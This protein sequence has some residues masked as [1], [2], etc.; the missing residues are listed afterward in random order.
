MGD[1]WFPLHLGGDF[2]RVRK[3]S[4]LLSTPI[5]SSSRREHVAEFLLEM[6]DR[7]PETNEI[8]L[9]MSRREI[10][11]HLGMTVE[12]VSR[13]FAKFEAIKAIARSDARHV[14]LRSRAAL[15]RISPRVKRQNKCSN[16]HKADFCDGLND[17]HFRAKAEHA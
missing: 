9:P 10:A 8:E 13:T 1:A 14:K 6:A 17:V 7:S 15:E 12:T 5:V 16:W 11:D 2:S 4:C 3:A